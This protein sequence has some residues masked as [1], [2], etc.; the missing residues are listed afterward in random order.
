MNLSDEIQAVLLEFITQQYRI[1][2]ND[3]ELEQ[4]LV[5][6]GVIDSFAFVEIAAFLEK[7]FSIVVADND[8]NVENFG[9]I[10]GIISFVRNLIEKR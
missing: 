2:I 8:I 4:N 10:S 6:M 1:D 9:T 3:I 5:D 7:Q